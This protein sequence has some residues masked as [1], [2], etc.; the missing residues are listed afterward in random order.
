MSTAPFGVRW[1]TLAL[2]FL[3]FGYFAYLTLL[4]LA[5]NPYRLVGSSAGILVFLSLLYPFAHGISF[6]LLTVFALWAFRALP[7]VPICG[8]LSGY[9]AVTESLQ[10]FIP[11]RTAEGLDFLQDLAGI[12]VGMLCS[13]MLAAGWKMLRKIKAEVCPEM[14]S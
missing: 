11:P 10:M 3:F 8:G 14:T 6:A 13:W 1:Q 2:R 12:A 7:P 4:L 5:P 9:A